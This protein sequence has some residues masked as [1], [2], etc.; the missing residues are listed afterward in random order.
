MDFDCGIKN[1]K[2]RDYINSHRYSLLYKL[3]EI[4]PD[5]CY[6][7]EDTINGSVKGR[8]GICLCM[9]FRFISG[10]HRCEVELL[11]C[12]RS[13][14]YIIYF[15][16]ITK[17]FGVRLYYDQGLLTHLQIVTFD[18]TSINDLINRFGKDNVKTK[19]NYGIYTIVLDLYHIYDNKIGLE[20][21]DY[22]WLEQRFDL[23]LKRYCDIFSKRA[24]KQI[25]N[26]RTSIQNM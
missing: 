2:M 23:E 15:Y 1:P 3:R 19:R 7:V 12:H 8:R 20:I 14:F 4:D 24:C 10:K 11:S 13:N 22:S 16:N 17:D 21:D 6:T 26:S 25:K 9:F 18:R 5:L